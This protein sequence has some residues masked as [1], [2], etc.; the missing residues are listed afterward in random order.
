MARIHKQ[1]DVLHTN[2]IEVLDGRNEHLSPHFRKGN[3]LVS[4]HQTHSVA[5]INLESEKVVWALTG[6]WNYQHQPTF[7]QNGNLLVFGNNVW[8][9]KSRV[10]EVNPLTQEVEWEYSGDDVITFYT[11]SCGSNQ[12]LPN[13][14]TLIIESDNGRAFEV[15]R[16]KEIVW[17]YMNPHRAGEQKELIATLF[18][19]V[20]IDDSFP[21][22]WMR[23]SR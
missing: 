2:T 8:M 23:R 5:V 17:E 15:T 21:T 11:K 6:L 12:R 10:V 14:N 7:L 20:R 19:V 1:L 9:E 18:D 22:G 4:L 3:V 13:G 16:D